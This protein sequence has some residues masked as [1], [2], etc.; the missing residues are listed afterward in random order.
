MRTSRCTATVD[1]LNADRDKS[2]WHELWAGAVAVNELCVKRGR[3]GVSFG[4]GRSPFL[5]PSTDIIPLTT[6][7]M[8]VLRVDYSL[9][10]LKIK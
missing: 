10:W 5:F 6:S 8:Q 3:A 1:I 9:N 7:D 2:S 4:L